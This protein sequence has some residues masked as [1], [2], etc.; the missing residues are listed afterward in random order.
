MGCVPIF[1]QWWLLNMPQACA[2]GN[3]LIA[4]SWS[5]SSIQCEIWWN[6]VEQP[7]WKQNQKE[8]CHKNTIHHQLKDCINSKQSTAIGSFVFKNS[9]TT[10]QLR[11]YDL[12]PEGSCYLNKAIKANYIISNVEV[13]LW[14]HISLGCLDGDIVLTSCHAEKK[15]RMIPLPDKQWQLQRTMMHFMLTGT[16]QQQQY[17]VTSPVEVEFQYMW[18]M[19][20]YIYMSGPIAHQSPEVHQT[21]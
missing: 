14:K 10:L 6:E 19:M 12:R 20:N 3:W 13:P 18:C 15:T 11:L 17:K 7:K 16:S 2:A 9:V 5:L 21:S 4:N 8:A 1:V